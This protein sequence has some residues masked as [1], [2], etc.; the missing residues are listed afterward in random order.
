MMY[1]SIIKFGTNNELCST[2]KSYLFIN[3]VGHKQYNLYN[4]SCDI[5]RV[6]IP[7]FCYASSGI[8]FRRIAD[9]EKS[10]VSVER[11]QEYQNTPVEAAM[12]LDSDQQLQDSWPEQGEVEFCNYATRYRAGMDLVLR[13]I[14]FKILPKEKIGIVGR[15]GAGKSSLTLSLFRMIESA[16][17]INGGGYISIDGINIATLGLKKLRNALT[18]IPQVSIVC[19]KIF[20]TN[21]SHGKRIF[22]IRICLKYLEI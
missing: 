15:T 22:K 9:M 6:S 21:A 16:E 14:S 12:T 11:I 2:A 1:C 19:P 4:V 17:D 3:Y 13:G 5:T 20:W 8:F 7:P 10:V 18:I